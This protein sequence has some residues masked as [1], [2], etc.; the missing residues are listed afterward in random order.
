MREV[1]ARN[2]FWVLACLCA[3]LTLAHAGDMEWFRWARGKDVSFGGALG[4]MR[5][6][7]TIPVAADSVK[8]LV[9]G[10]RQG[11]LHVL[12][13]AEGRSREVWVSQSL[14]SSVAEVFVADV[15]ADGVLE[16]VAYSHWG[17][18]V[19][20]NADSYELIWRSKDDEYATISAMAIENLDGDPQLELVFLGE[21]E[22]A[23]GERDSRLFVYDARHL[24]E[25]RRGEQTLIGE[26]IVVA[27]LDEDAELE[28]AINTGVVI[29][30]RSLDFEWHFGGCDRMG[31]VD[32]NYDGTPD[33]IGE[34]GSLRPERHIR[35]ISITSD[36]RGNHGTEVSGR[37][38]DCASCHKLRAFCQDCHER[39]GVTSTVG[40]QNPGGRIDED[41]YHLRE[42]PYFAPYG[43]VNECTNCHKPELREVCLACHQRTVPDGEEAIRANT[44]IYSILSELKDR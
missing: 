6:V 11:L 44:E 37:I 24:A 40:H 17:D 20:Y 41:A 12:E 26:S 39:E 32:V 2:V 34:Y 9:Y 35:V 15:N 16:I 22:D 31:Y 13:F 19:I 27:N 25:E 36:F 4:E 43:N 7:R 3:G 18:I 21:A 14:K 8:R 1:F 29:D 28:I 23:S 10:D 30:A 33:L 42:A 38:A 5:T